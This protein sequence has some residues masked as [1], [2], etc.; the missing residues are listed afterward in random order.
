[1]SNL[2]LSFDVPLVLT[3]LVLV[4]GAV[5]LLDICCFSKKRIAGEK[6]PLLIEYARSFFPVFFLVLLLRSFLIQPYRVPTGSLA[7]TV[8]PGDFI[9]VKQYSYGLRMP[10]LNTKIV[11]IGE[12][13]RGDIALFRFPHDLSKIYVKRVIGLP[14]DHVVYREKLL[15][16][17]NQL[18]WQTPIGMDLDVE[19]GFSVPVQARVEQLDQITH[20]IFIKPGYKDWESV[21]L[22]VP[23][24]FYFM[25][26][27]NR[28]N[29]VDSR[30][31]GLVPEANLVGKAVAIWLSWDSEK[32][33]VRWE[34]IG[35]KIH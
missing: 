20:K 2:N 14:G 8:L 7:P 17:N 31:W 18:A 21:D 16:I 11:N 1:M 4:S 13:K 6:Q 19:N 33:G 10:V 9:V 24:G 23:Q 26:G 22:M 25:M 28:D 15:T 12:P 30:V 35:K 34:R 5:S 29:S 3:L 27:D 32:I